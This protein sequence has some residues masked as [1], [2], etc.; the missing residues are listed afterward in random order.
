MR[1]ED[2][3][4]S[5]GPGAWELAA[6]YS[7]IDLNDGTGKNRVQG[8]KMDGVTVGLNWYWNDNLKFQFDWVY[9]HR[10]DLPP[11]SLAGYTSGLGMR[12]QFMY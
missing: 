5:W 11:G 3:R 8:G 9:D 1:N 4:L 7:Y 6:R 10:Y 12:V 2:G